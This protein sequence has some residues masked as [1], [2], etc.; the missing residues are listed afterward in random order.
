MDIRNV[1][2]NLLKTAPIGG[3]K[4]SEK[5]AEKSDKMSGNSDDSFEKVQT[6]ED[7]L[8]QFI[9]DKMEEQSKIDKGILDP[10]IAGQVSAQVKMSMIDGFQRGGQKSDWNPAG[11]AG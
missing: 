1:D 7:V 11:M 5:S 6:F 8:S 4:G 10:S 2:L 3:N 9:D